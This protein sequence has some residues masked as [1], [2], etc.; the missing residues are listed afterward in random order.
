LLQVASASAIPPQRAESP[1]RSTTG[2]DESAGTFGEMLDASAG[3]AAPGP[4]AAN[5]P[6]KPASADPSKPQDQSKP[7]DDVAAAA[8]AVAAASVETAVSA[9]PD[10]ATDAVP[11]SPINLV[12][13]AQA[14]PGTPDGS[15]AP[16][17]AGK[18]KNADSSALDAGA[19]K[20]D[21]KSDA[22]EDVAAAPIADSDVTTA[23]IPVASIV[24]V[25]VVA[26]PAAIPTAG[27]PNTE[28]ADSIPTIAA[29]VSAPAIDSPPPQRPAQLAARSTGVPSAA[30]NNDIAPNKPDPAVPTAVVASVGAGSEA[31]A[32][33]P[34]DPSAETANP[35]GETTKADQ[36][37]APALASADTEEAAPTATATTSDKPAKPGEA[38]PAAAQVETKALP[39]PEQQIESPKNEASKGEVRKAADGKIESGKVNDAPRGVAKSA[40][41]QIPGDETRA[42]RNAEDASRAAHQSHEQAGEHA[43]AAAR[44]ALAAT[45]SDVGA[46]STIAQAVT[47]QLGT[48]AAGLTLA[49]PLASPLQS[50]WQAA[51]ERAEASDQ[52]V[53]IAGVAVAIMSRAEDGLRR[54]EIRLDPPELGRIDV[55]LDVDNSGKVTS[56]LAVDRPATLDLLRRDAPQLERALQ[57]AGLNTEGGLQ[58]SLRDQNFANREQTPQNT[59]TLIVPD[60]EPTAAEAVRRGY[61]RLVGLGSGIDIRV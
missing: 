3:T 7:A 20:S 40:Q 28:N 49:T 52:A 39:R 13:L 14:I 16:V 61:G 15:V 54:F 55:R 22:S 42:P 57:H 48:P 1:T 10:A 53:P 17:P 36:T 56:H 60:D 44:A 2:S 11:A 4:G 38:E 26:P 21:Q 47:T 5:A 46:P 18:A 58:F 43:A 30:A 19:A 27:Q 29:R 31:E 35:S 59:P 32:G 8:A 34:A 23:A 37:T 51:P 12:L 33:E 45:P 6:G 50:I 25:A 9:E 24:A 41:P